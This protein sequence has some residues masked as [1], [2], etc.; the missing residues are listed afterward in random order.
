MEYIRYIEK[1]H[2]YYRS[3]GYDKTYNYAYNEDTP[4]TPLKKALSECRATLVTT[5]SFLLMSEDG[6]QL[7]EPRLIGTN[8]VEVFTVPSDWAAER[9][10]SSSEDHDRYQTDMADVNAFF[11]TMRMREFLEE[12]I[13]GSLSRNYYRTLPNYSHRKTREVDGP[14]I[15][16]QC[17]EDHVGCEAGDVRK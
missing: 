1:T 14:E 12:G 9:I 8:E 15:L 10:L 3:L 16:R 4:F 7:E 13:F 2:E 17:L 6:L 11:P 5:A